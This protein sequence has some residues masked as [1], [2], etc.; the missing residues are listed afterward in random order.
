[1]A[2]DLWRTPPEVFEYFNRDYSFKYDACA[3]DNNHLCKDYLTEEDN[4]LKGGLS[5]L[6]KAGDFA[7][8]NPPYSNPLPFVEQC[9]A[10]AC[11]DGI[12]YVMLLNH[13]MSTRWA[14][15]LS[16]IECEIVVFTG[17]RI[18]FLNEFGVPVKGN[19]KG[20]IAVVIPPFVRSGK[21][22]TR[23]IPLEDVMSIGGIVTTEI[24]EAA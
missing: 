20:Q 13:D 12:G 14:K 1:M 7:W 9:V 8:N 3:S 22:K 10:D 2:N 19:N 18:A 6:V 15:L 21:P 11:F 24:R 17:K 23:Y 5:G 4:F 16:E